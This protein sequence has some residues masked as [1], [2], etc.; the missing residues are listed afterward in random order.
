MM[1][2]DPRESPEPPPRTVITHLLAA[3]SNSTEAA[4]QLLALVYG[5]L[6]ALARAKMAREQPGQTLQPTA[7]VHEA[8]LRIVD[9]EG[10]ARFANRA[11]F[12]GA[13]AEAMRRI[14]IDR[15]RRKLAARHGGGLERVD[16]E[17]VDIAAPTADDAELLAIH[18]ALDA[19]TVHE[20]R[21]AE[22]VKLRYFAGLSIEET[23]N[24]LAIST[25]T[26]KRDWT[27]ARA[28]LFRKI[29][30]LEASPEIDGAP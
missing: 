4:E 13:A 11:H 8:W 29:K 5:E 22:L 3:E 6:R 9:A 18:E 19:L 10:Q 26:A 1:S 7:L 30:Q 27:Y 20:P 17:A 15:A 16:A 25:A 12:F 24:V 28:W 2:D 23:A 14:L 21:K